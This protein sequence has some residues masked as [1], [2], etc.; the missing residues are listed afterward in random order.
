MAIV[1]SRLMKDS[2]SE[3]IEMLGEMDYVEKEEIRQVIL[4]ESKALKEKE[5]LQ[6]TVPQYIQPNKSL[7]NF[8]L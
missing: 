8:C 4:E 2:D 6:A 7:V 1:V 5:R 3:V